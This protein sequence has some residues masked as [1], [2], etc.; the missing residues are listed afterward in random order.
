MLL[1]S[2]FDCIRKINSSSIFSLFFLY[3]SN[4]VKK[5]SKKVF[6]VDKYNELIRPVDKM[7]VTNVN[8]ELKL[9]QIDLVSKKIKRNYKFLFNFKLLGRKISRVYIYSL[10]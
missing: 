9:L 6:T 1:S 10:V 7:G 2:E 8:T 5:N 3:F 4:Q